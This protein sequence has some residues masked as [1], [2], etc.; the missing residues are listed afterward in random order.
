MTELLVALVPVFAVIAA[1]TVFR[2]VGFPGDGF[3]EPAEKLAYY[4]LLPALLVG[5]L[6]GADLAGLDVGRF[7]LT[8]A[9]A[10]LAVGALLLVAGPRLRLGGAPFATAFMGSIRFNTYAGLAVVVSLF[11][12]MGLTLFSVLIGVMIPLLNVMSVAALARFIRGGSAVQIAG[13]LARNPLVLGCLAGIA[14]NLSG[15]G[16]HPVA[17]G[18]LE[19]LGKA[20]LGLA[21]LAVGAGLDLA[22]LRGSIGLVAAASA[23]KLVAIPL[24]VAAACRLTGVE[25]VPYMVAVLYAALPTSPQGYILARQ[26]G[27]DGPLIAAIVSATTAAS[28]LT[29]PLM[30]SL[31][32]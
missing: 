32:A 23:V 7:I 10:F 15:L 19:I 5:N 14:I 13:M 20:A 28:I 29:I 2:R 31:L 30:L 24:A 1:G 17:A 25:G 12:D 16:I 8:V 18:V 9:G 4:V 11:G 22:A 27:G 21:L 26:M 6:A 3:W